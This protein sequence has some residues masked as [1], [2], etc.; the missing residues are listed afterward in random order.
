MVFPMDFTTSP[1]AADSAPAPAARFAATRESA[2][3]ANVS[4]QAATPGGPPLTAMGRLR[5]GVWPT[6]KYLTGTEVHTYAFSVAANAV[7]SFFPFFVMM[8]TLARRVFQSPRM[9]NA[10]RLLLLAYLPAS[11][12]FIVGTLVNLARA[13]HGIQVVSL[14]MLLITSTGVFLPLEVALNH[15]WG[16]RKNRSYLANQ[17]VALSLAIGC[18][19][20]ALGS[21]ALTASNYTFLTMLFLGHTQNIVF[22]LAARVVTESFAVLASIAIYFLIYWV[23]PHGKIKVRWV[24]PAAVTAGVVQEIA[25]FG[26]IAVLPLLNFKEVYGPFYVS[27]SLIFW[28]YVWG[29]LLL[30]GAHLSAFGRIPGPQDSERE[31]L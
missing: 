20:L 16:F 30:G 22:T 26:Y 9:F 23:L 6:L 7:L 2:P 25:K 17:A 21:C 13:R 8:M 28:G 4:P 5:L 31:I 11:Q 18:A 27:V 14:V 12:D 24:L 19:A 29:M 1:D 3:G 10:I 15:V